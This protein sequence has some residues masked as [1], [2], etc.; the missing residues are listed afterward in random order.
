MIKMDEIALFEIQ[1]AI[2]RA[3]ARM[4]RGALVCKDCGRQ[5]YVNEDYARCFVC[6][7]V[8]PMKT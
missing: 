7:T 3:R 4:K 2:N 1:Q 6:K 8:Y 5:M